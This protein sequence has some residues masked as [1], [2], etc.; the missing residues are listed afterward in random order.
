[1][2]D[3]N[4]KTDVISIIVADDLSATPEP[5]PPSSSFKAIL[6]GYARFPV[7]QAGLS[8]D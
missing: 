4:E 1:V 5:A 6:F 8:V 3:I 7:R 2:H